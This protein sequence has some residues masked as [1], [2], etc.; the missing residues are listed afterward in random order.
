MPGI[1]CKP[2]LDRKVRKLN[3]QGLKDTPYED[4]AFH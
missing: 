3:E 1:F 4:K 2:A